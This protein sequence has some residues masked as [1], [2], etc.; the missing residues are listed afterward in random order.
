MLQ[1]TAELLD[2]LEEQLEHDE[3]GNNVKLADRSFSF[4]FVMIV[5]VV[6]VYNYLMGWVCLAC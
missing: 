6:S 1:V 5:A 2:A 3:Y 4:L